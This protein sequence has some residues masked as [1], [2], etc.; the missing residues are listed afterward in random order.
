MN[1]GQSPAP[2]TLPRAL[3]DPLCQPMMR[4][5]RLLVVEDSRLCCESIRQMFRGSGGRLRRAETLT[6]AR[7][8]LS[9]YTPDAALIDL[10]L[11]DGSGLELIAEI[12]RKRPRVPLIIAISGQPELEQDA[13]NAGADRFLAKPFCSVA[14]FRAQLA[15]IFFPFRHGEHRAEAAP[16]DPSALR[17]DLYLA[18]DLLSG[19]RRGSTRDYALQFIDTLACSLSDNGM[20][21]AV[22]LARAEGRIAPLVA[23]MRERLRTQP[24]V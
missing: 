8:H 14:H 3:I 13:R 12:D 19:E 22:R 11:P 17:D 15:P 2:N 16:P 10:G 20:S 23:T 18:L 9:F 7:R 1:T 6:S 21:Q 5:G 24:L 4:S